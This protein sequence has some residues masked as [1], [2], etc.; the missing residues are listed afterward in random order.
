MRIG[1]TVIIP[2]ILALGMAGSVLAGSEMAAAAVSAP[3]V[4][5]QQ[6]PIISVGPDMRYHD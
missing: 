5:A 2:V 4:H 3:S 1:R 6:A